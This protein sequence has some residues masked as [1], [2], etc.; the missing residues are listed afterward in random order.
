MVVAVP[1]LIRHAPRATFSPPRGEKGAR[2][3][4]DPPP[5]TLTPALQSL[6]LCG[7]SLA[8]FFP[9]PRKRVFRAAFVP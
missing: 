2:Y 4:T 8:M 7:H 1:A 3:L 9:A 5:Q 6:L